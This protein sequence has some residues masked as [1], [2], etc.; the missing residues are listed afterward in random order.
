[1]GLAARPARR[2]GSGGGSGSAVTAGYNPVLSA[3]K[4]VCMYK[5]AARDGYAALSCRKMSS[6]D[7]CDYLSEL[8]EMV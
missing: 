7:S 5:V 4:E 1:M 3:G 6:G 8:V 2:L